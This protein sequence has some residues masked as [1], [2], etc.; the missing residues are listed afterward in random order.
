M[1]RNSSLTCSNALT[2]SRRALVST[3]ANARMWVLPCTAAARSARLAFSTIQSWLYDS[4]TPRRRLDGLHGAAHTFA[5]VGQQGRL[6]VQPLQGV[7]LVEMQVGID[8]G[9]GDETPGRVQHDRGRQVRRFLDDLD[10]SRAHGD[11]VQRFRPAPQPPPSVSRDRM[12][13]SWLLPVGFVCRASFG[14]IRRKSNCNGPSMGFVVES[15]R[16]D[17]SDRNLSEVGEGT[18]APIRTMITLTRVISNCYPR[19]AVAHAASRRERTRPRAW[20]PRPW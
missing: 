20:T 1:P 9:F 15:R 7:D 5:V 11:V 12:V 10:S 19:L 6:L 3:S 18:H 14:D 13:R 17:G 16:V 8:E 2:P 4:L